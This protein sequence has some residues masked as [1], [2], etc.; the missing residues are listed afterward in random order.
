[1][2]SNNSKLCR[3]GINTLWALSLLPHLAFVVLLSSL[4]RSRH[5]GR[6]AHGI[7]GAAA[8]DDDNV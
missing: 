3:S 6:Q 4:E 2:D 7:Q 1:M 8:L 5:G